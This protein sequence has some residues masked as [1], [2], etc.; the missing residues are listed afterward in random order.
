MERYNIKKTLSDILSFELA[1]PCRKVWWCQKSLNTVIDKSILLQLLYFSVVSK[2]SKI[3][4]H[5]RLELVSFYFNIEQFEL[6]CE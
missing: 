5:F 4:Y 3:K 6:K 1:D 2:T